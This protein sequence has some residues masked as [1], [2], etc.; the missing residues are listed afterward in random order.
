MLYLLDEG[1]PSDFAGQ[2]NQLFYPEQAGPV[3]QHIR[4]LIALGT[5]DTDWMATLEQRMQ[6][7]NEERNGPSLHEIG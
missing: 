3:V 4:D 6:T 5:A 1:W 2:L 7:Y